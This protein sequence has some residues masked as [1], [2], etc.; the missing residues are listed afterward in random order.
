MGEDAA[1]AAAAAAA[2]GFDHAMPPAAAYG[3]YKP[4]PAARAKSAAA[5]SAARFLKQIE[6]CSVSNHLNINQSNNKAVKIFVMHFLYRTYFFSY[7]R[8]LL[9]EE[10]D[11]AVELVQTLSEISFSRISQAKMVG[12]SLLYCS[13][14]FTTCGVATLGFEPPIIPGGRMVPVGP[15]RHILRII[16]NLI[17]NIG[18]HI[19]AIN[20]NKALLN[21]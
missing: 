18:R 21:S 16:W 8:I 20:R 15:R 6:K 4:Y 14:L 13:I 3:L 10:T 5:R 17:A 7:L 19:F 11:G 2:A 9:M 1:A 12:F